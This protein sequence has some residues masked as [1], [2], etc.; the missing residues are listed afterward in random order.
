MSE[1]FD[2]LPNRYGTN[3]AKW[4]GAEQVFGEKD[5]L[6]LW[7]ADMD[8]RAPQPVIDKLV[9]LTKQGIY[10]YTDPFPSYYEA[11]QGWIKKAYDWDV[12][13]DWIVFCPRIV[14]A[15]SLI[16]QNFTAKGDK[17]IVQTPGYHPI[18][19]AV[20]INE[21]VVVENQL[22]YMNGRYEINFKDL[23]QK[24]Q[25]GAKAM[26]L[27][28]PHNPVG[29]VWTR[30]ELLQLANLCVEYDVM[31]ISDDI[32]ADFIYEGH[33]HIPVAT[34]SERI[35]EQSI[36]CTSPGKTFNLAGIE[37][38]NIVIPNTQW[39]DK[40]KL[41]LQQAGIHNPN[42]FAVPAVEAAYNEGQEWLDEAWEYIKANA[43]YAKQ[44]I[45]AHMPKLQIIEPEGTYLLWIDAS[46][47][48]G[49]EAD[50]KQWIV[51]EAKVGV[52]FGS[53]FGNG[54]EGF[55]RINVATP[56]ALLEEGLQRL[57]RTYHTRS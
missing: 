45:A 24:M 50:L 21:R 22:L 2:Q 17:I 54:G 46:A 49:K 18:I 8:L 53:S 42:F 55:F 9:A 13:K 47:Y 44:Y 37:V 36:I 3:C 1:Y 38:C 4:D 14:Q 15:V 27:V 11:T 52:S 28:T 35:A 31:L 34:L 30:D 19:N 26:L 32:H 40:F 20:E 51:H 41:C 10:G 23:E 48:M 43:A 56:R 12:P 33:R 57:A 39:R 29:R 6:P 5:I 25:Q 7:V 16:I